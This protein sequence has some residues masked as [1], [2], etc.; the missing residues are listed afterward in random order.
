MALLFLYLAFTRILQ[1]LALSRRD[2]DELA[3]RSSCSAMKLPCPPPG[4]TEHPRRHGGDHPP[5]G[6]G[7]P[8]LG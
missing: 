5:N 1:V 2:S 7:E 3:L 6:P 4:S 8:H